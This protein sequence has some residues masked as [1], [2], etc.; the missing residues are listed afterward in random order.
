MDVEPVNDKGM[1]A[2]TIA[3]A[4]HPLTVLVVVAVVRIAIALAGLEQLKADP[5]SYRHLAE[6]FA[7]TGVYGRPDPA[8]GTIYPTAYR[9]PLYPLLLACFATDHGV[10]RFWIAALHVTLGVGTVAFVLRAGKRLRLGR[11][12][13]VA[14]LLTACD[15][16]L[17]RQSTL[18]MT[19][20]LAAFLAAGGLVCAV[21]AIAVVTRPRVQRKS[22]FGCDSAWAVVA[23]AVAGLAALCRP[24]FLPW[25]AGLAAAMFVARWLTRVRD[26]DRNGAQARAK[27]PAVTTAN[28]S[29]K[30]VARDTDS[31]TGRNLSR[32]SGR[33]ASRDTSRDTFKLAVKLAAFVL[34]GGLA[35]I[36]PWVVRNGWQMGRWIATTTHGGYTLLLGNNPDFYASLAGPSP[37]GLPW[38]LPGDDYLME[39]CRESLAVGPRAAHDRLRGAA[40]ELAEDELANRCARR[41]IAADPVAFGRASLYRLGQFWSPLPQAT[42]V[43]ESRMTWA[44][45]HGIAMWYLAVGV[46]AAWGLL[47]WL[48][49]ISRVASPLLRRR[50]AVPDWTGFRRVWAWSPLVALLLCFSAAHTFYWSNLRMRG[51]IMP[52]VCLL[53]A[54]GIR[55][56]SLRGRRT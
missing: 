36:A 3:V 41:H 15:P 30:P 48:A 4:A 5:D 6:T 52:A 27:M 34:A 13:A 19:E 49:A 24:T 25:L 43:G 47:A 17:L 7:R 56:S 23:G 44:V 54:A 2:R 38:R 29:N 11:L 33:D 45:R 50:V 21:E 42:A 35:V 18:V 1:R 9:P 20:T 26:G 28:L 39:R 16:I 31:D 8:D 37:D 10:S 12:A 14:G 22:V 40:W 55:A 46:F 51:P 32:D 53:A